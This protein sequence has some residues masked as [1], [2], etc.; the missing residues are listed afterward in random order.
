ML[1]RREADE[2][3]T[4]QRLLRQIERSPRDFSYGTTFLAA[5]LR[6]IQ[7]RK[8]DTLNL[9]PADWTDHLRRAA[10]VDLKARAQ[11]LVPSDDLAQR[12]FERLGIERPN[13][14]DRSRDVVG[15]A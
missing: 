3:R 13:Q 11:G 10:L 14:S 6:L 4:Q 2:S 7:P 1:V 12:A 5:P 9:E 8:I 15:R